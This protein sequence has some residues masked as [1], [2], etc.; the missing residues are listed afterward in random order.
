[1]KRG[2]IRRVAGGPTI[3]Q[4]KLALAAAGLDA[5]DRFGPVYIDDLSVAS[6]IINSGTAIDIASG[7]IT[8]SSRSIVKSDRYQTLTCD[9]RKQP[10]SVEQAAAKIC[11]DSAVVD[12]EVVYQ[13]SENIC[14]ATL[15]TVS[16]AQ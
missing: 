11:G 7:W 8:G 12:T 1:M 6:G 16:C 14:S 15:I 2:Y 9:Q 13:V 5:A 4:Q 10:N 3:K